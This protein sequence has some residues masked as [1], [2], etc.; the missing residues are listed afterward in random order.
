MER[1]QI[2]IDFNRGVVA[3][4]RAS[5]LLPLGPSVYSP[6]KKH[7]HRVQNHYYS[8]MTSAEELPIEQADEDKP[9][10]LAGMARSRTRLI[11]A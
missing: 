7:L 1:I 5:W 10:W 3:A 6:E 11:L 4:G 2:I 9:Q 8:P